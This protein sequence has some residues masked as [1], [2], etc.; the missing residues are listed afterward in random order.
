MLLIVLDK[1]R[2]WWC[3]NFSS[4]V[5]LHFMNLSTRL[6]LSTRVI[7]VY[8][9]VMLYS[10]CSVLIEA[11]FFP[12]QLARRSVLLLFMQ[13]TILND[14]SS[15]CIDDEGYWPSLEVSDERSLPSSKV[16]GSL[17]RLLCATYI[18]YIHP[19]QFFSLQLGIMFVG[20][21]CL[22]KKILHLYGIHI[23]CISLSITSFRAIKFIDNSLFIYYLRLIL[24]F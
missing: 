21:L 7:T 22:L 10:S 23:W 4:F 8:V 11:L 13:Q 9:V 2:R 12:L 6:I 14:N 17:N 16:I 20:H 15:L 5:I 18:N 3:M 1:N 24:I 19:V